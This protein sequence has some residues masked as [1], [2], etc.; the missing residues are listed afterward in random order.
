[1]KVEKYLFAMNRK[2]LNAYYVQP[3]RDLTFEE[4]KNKDNCLITEWWVAKEITKWLGHQCHGDF[5][6]PAAGLA[7]AEPT[8]SSCCCP[9]LPHR[10]ALH[11]LTYGHLWGWCT[12]GR[13]VRSH[14]CTKVIYSNS[15]GRCACSPWQPRLWQR[16]KSYWIPNSLLI[17][18]YYYIALISLLL[19]N[20]GGFFHKGYLQKC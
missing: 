5:P 19:L 1:M 6:T 18:W 12:S 7:A 11:S 14:V 9:G 10:C 20:S 15:R 3:E 4:K 2:L 8:P 13:N 16:Y 17:L